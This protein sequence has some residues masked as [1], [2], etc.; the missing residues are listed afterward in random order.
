MAKKSSGSSRPGKLVS[1]KAED[2]L[3]KPLTRAQRADLS[4]LKNRRDSEI[5]FS[6]IPPL[7]EKQLATA[8]QPNRQLIAVRLDREVLA[9]LRGF[10]PGYS[11]RINN[12]LR[13]VVENAVSS[14]R[15]RRT[16][17]ANRAEKL[18]R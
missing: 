13:V 3:G 9:W 17:Q 12:I 8:F 18:D 2:I 4:R 7:T 16:V 15:P 14:S 10:G 5:G 6:D 11:T 1:V